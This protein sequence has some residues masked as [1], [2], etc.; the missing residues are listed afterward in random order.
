[1]PLFKKKES[2]I[3]TLDLTNL[4][5][6]GTLQ[7]SLALSNSRSQKEGQILD[8]TNIKSNAQNNSTVDKQVTDD[9]S[10]FFDTVA[11]SSI[12]TSTKSEANNSDIDVK[13]DNLEYKLSRLIERL[14]VIEKKIS[15][16]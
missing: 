15:E 13:L 10:S 16:N 14:E 3:D 6:K 2:N 5:E 12:P 4:Q 9:F 11:S 1:M 7:R 8:F